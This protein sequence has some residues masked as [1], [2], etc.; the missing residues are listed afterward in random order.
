MQNEMNRF[1]FHTEPMLFSHF[2]QRYIFFYL[3]G[4]AVM[5]FIGEILSVSRL[6]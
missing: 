4:K 5:G 3:S 1:V 2:M 6:I